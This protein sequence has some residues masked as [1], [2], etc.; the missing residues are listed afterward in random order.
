VRVD[1]GPEG[2]DIQEAGARHVSNWGGIMITG[3]E[4]EYLKA[5]MD[6][7]GCRGGRQPAEGLPKSMVN[8][9]D[10]GVSGRPAWIVG[11]LFAKKKKGGFENSHVW[12]LSRGLTQTYRVGANSWPRK[13]GTRKG[14]GRSGGGLGKKA[15]RKGPNSPLRRQ[16]ASAS[17]RVV[18]RGRKQLEVEVERGGKREP[19]KEKI[20]DTFG[21]EG[22]FI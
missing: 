13:R 6:W 11:N 16:K 9:R 15:S 21:T 17:E 1:A 2:E 18:V 7:S 5:I 22:S 14:P 10:L 4:K 20:R 12:T 3:L 8:C 19:G